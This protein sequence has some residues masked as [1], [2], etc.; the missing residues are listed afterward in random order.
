MKKLAVIGLLVGIFLLPTLISIQRYNTDIGSYNL[1]TKW[2][3]VNYFY[4]NISNAEWLEEQGKQIILN[5]DFSDN[6]LY[7]VAN[8][9]TSSITDNYLRA[10]R[11]TA[12]TNQSVYYNQYYTNTGDLYY[13]SVD[14]YGDT[15][16]KTL[17][18]WNGVQYLQVEYDIDLEWNNYSFIFEAFGEN[19]RLYWQ[20]SSLVS[21][22]WS[23][24]YD[25]W[26]AYN[27]SELN[28][29]E[30]TMEEFE[31]WLQ[32]PHHREKVYYNELEN[33]NLIDNSYFDIDILDSSG[34]TNWGASSQVIP[35]YVDIINQRAY[36][37]ATDTNTYLYQHGTGI[38]NHTYYYSFEIDIINGQAQLYI[39][40]IQT[41]Y[42][43]PNGYV[44]GLTTRQTDSNFNRFFIKRLTT[45]SEFYIDNVVMYDL[46]EIF[47]GGII[48]DINEFE[49]ILERYNTYK[50]TK[51]IG[52]YQHQTEDQTDID[53]YALGD[54]NVKAFFRF[55]A[56]PINVINEFRIETGEIIGTWTYDSVIAPLIDLGDT[57]VDGI[58]QFFDD[59]WEDIKQ[60]GDDILDKL[61]FWN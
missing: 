23:A 55:V 16:S 30:Y 28:M 25:N 4:K 8:G 29:E 44:S 13:M 43:V 59:L 2:E 50:G 39:N 61:T 41:I 58:G 20:M 56:D 17:T 48:P 9:G 60:L 52:L 47:D 36:L 53:G 15:N 45:I 32:E 40:D 14:V 1:E 22:N 11:T 37:N 34:W 54:L 33:Y 10:E 21:R 19:Q 5:S 3:D 38:G 35:N 31:S 27:L 6:N 26:K 18:T 12:S 57:I 51:T 42:S 7:V 46:N 24:N 49:D